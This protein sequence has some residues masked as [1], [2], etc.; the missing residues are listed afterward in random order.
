ME[1]W[2]DLAIERY[3][4][5]YLQIGRTGIVPPRPTWQE[6]LDSLQLETITIR[7]ESK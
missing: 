7:E 5:N 4:A 2:Q 3:N 6:F 1:A